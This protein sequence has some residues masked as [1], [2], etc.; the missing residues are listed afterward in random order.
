MSLLAI[1]RYQFYDLIEK[2]Y[3]YL[4]WE[5]FAGREIELY[6]VLHRVT[7]VVVAAFE[8]WRRHRWLAREL[9]RRCWLARELRRRR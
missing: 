3:T 2:S 5:G 1:N 7:R 9:K 8:G 6:G 4:E